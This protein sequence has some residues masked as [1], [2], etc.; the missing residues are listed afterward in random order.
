MTKPF[1]IKVETFKQAPYK[2]V[3]WKLHDKCNYNCSFCGDENKLGIFGWQDLETNKK[4]VDGIVEGCKGHPFW[5]QITGGEPTLYPKFIELVTYMKEKGAR[6]RLISNGSRTI[7][8]WKELRNA[9]IMDII[10]LTFHSEQRADYKHIAEVANLFLDAETITVMPVTYVPH[11]LEYALEGAKYLV[12]NT[13]S[14]ISMNAMDLRFTPE[15][16]RNFQEDQFKEVLEKYNTAVGD[17]MD[18]KTK[19][20][21]PEQMLAMYDVSVT[22]SDGTVQQKDPTIMMKLGENKFEGWLCYAGID[23][24]S[25]ENNMKFRGG[26]K[27]GGTPMELG[28]FTFF[29]EPFVCDIDSCYCAMDM[30]TT[31]IKNMD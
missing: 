31:K 4:I 30:V 23:S 1:P 21:I 27:R 19:T 6:V 24:I 13:G 29:D 8:W 25:I 7:R 26:C 10:F 2:L 5:I 28:E 20:T 12:E 3:E 15:E 14:Y 9:D 22:Y 18:K 17:L 16:E 11:S